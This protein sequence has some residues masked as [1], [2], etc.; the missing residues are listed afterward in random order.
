MSDTISLVGEVIDVLPGTRFRIKLQ[1]DKLVEGHLSGRLRQN[2]IKI[3][4]GD[5]VTVEISK[6]DLTKGRITYRGVKK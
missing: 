2:Y 3:V 5:K 6:Y 4:S 1:N